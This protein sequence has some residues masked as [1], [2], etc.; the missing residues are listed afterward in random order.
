MQ[1]CL[2]KIYFAWS[3]LSSAG[4]NALQNQ[5]NVFLLFN[6][7]IFLVSR[8]I[9]CPIMNFLVPMVFFFSAAACTLMILQ[10]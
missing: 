7:D 1:L 2:V 8:K 5:L 3:Q 4:R 10:G 6:Q 9:V